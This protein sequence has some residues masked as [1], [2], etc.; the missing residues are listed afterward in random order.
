MLITFRGSKIPDSTTLNR[1]ISLSSTSSALSTTNHKRGKNFNESKQ[2]SKERHSLRAESI[3]KTEMAHLKSLLG[4]DGDDLSIEDMSDTVIN[5][6][7]S[8]TR[9]NRNQ[10][11]HQTTNAVSSK[12]RES[13]KTPDSRSAKLLK[14]RP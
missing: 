13:F 3:N 14:K 2:H 1:S 6:L 7:L 8:S 10:S 12:K 9:E 5:E 4:P 11:S